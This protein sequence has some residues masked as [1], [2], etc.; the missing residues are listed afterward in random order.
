[1]LSVDKIGLN[2]AKFF[3]ITKKLGFSC[4]NTN[5]KAVIGAKNYPQNRFEISPGYN[6]AGGGLLIIRDIFVAIEGLQER[7]IFKKCKKI[8]YQ[9]RG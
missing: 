2:A 8:T 7:G 3:K 9:Q 6:Y 4:G 1:M 5:S